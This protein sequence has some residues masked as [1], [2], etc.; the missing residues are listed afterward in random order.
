MFEFIFISDFEKLSQV[1]D[2]WMGSNSSDCDV[3]QDYVLSVVMNATEIFA[4]Q[5]E[6]S[7]GRIYQIGDTATVLL[8][9]V[10]NIT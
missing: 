3:I 9:V 10:T 5:C 1:S 6:L 8:I 2:C 4:Q 7:L